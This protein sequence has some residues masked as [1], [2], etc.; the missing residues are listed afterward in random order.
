MDVLLVV[1]IWLFAI[2]H[3][4]TLVVLVAF[5]AD[6]EYQLGEIATGHYLGFSIGLVA[7]VL[8]A[9]LAAELL[10]GWTFLLGLVP[11][12]VGVWGLIRRRSFTGRTGRKT[13]PDRL[14]RISVVTIAGIG[15]SGENIAIFIPFFATLQG[16]ELAVVLFLYLIGAGILLLLAVPLARGTIAAGMPDW[17]DRWL[18]PGTL[19]IVGVYVL[20]AG[21]IAA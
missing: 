21:W 12:G 1:A 17:I 2:T 6:D 3:V 14:G 4:D 16:N 8:A 9:L 13:V 11:L 20:A 18:V 7:S 15:L 5:C 19:I 10:Y